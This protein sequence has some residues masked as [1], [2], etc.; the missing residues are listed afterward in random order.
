MA[1][2]VMPR[3][4]NAKRRAGGTRVFKAE[5]RWLLTQLAPFADAELS[6]LLNIGSST[7]A[8]REE[9]QPWIEQGLFAPLGRRHIEIVHVD[10]KSDDGVD[11]CADIMDAVGYDRIA[12]VKPRAL[13]L[14]NLL[15]HVTDP[16]AFAQRCVAVVPSGGLLFVTVPHSYPH[17]R[18][19][20]D[21]MFRPPPQALGALFSGTQML[22]GEIVDTGESY[23]DQVRRR[24]WILL[25]HLFR[26]PV[27]FLGIEKWKRSMQ[28]LYWLW[29]NYEMT[30]VVFQ[31]L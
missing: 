16:K 1:L 27:P 18:D 26:L 17:H 7:R 3:S 29:H 15:E 14:C 23:R 21:T 8:F 24:P 30:C 25:R 28:K 4:R 13:L 11:L 20:I 2:E 6:P 31:K 9:H 5:C 12:G 10:I 19:P 22:R